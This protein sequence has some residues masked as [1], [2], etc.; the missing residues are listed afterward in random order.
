MAEERHDFMAEEI[1]R[2][3]SLL[4]QERVEQRGLA[5]ERDR[6]V[7]QV[8]LCKSQIQTLKV[9][10]DSLLSRLSELKAQLRDRDG[11]GAS[12]QTVEYYKEL[13]RNRDSEVERLDREVMH[14]RQNGGQG[15]GAHVSQEEYERVIRELQELRRETEEHTTSARDMEESLVQR[16]EQLATS[17]TMVSE[18]AQELRQR[19]EML[20]SDYDQLQTDYNEVIEEL[21]EARVGERAAHARA[22]YAE[23]TVL[24]RQDTEGTN[25]N[26]N[27]SAQRFST[28]GLS[29]QEQGR[30]SEYWQQQQQQQQQ[31]AAPSYR[32][33]DGHGSAMA[34]SP[35][36]TVQ[37]QEHL[38]P[39]TTKSMRYRN[40]AF[41]NWGGQAYPVPQME[42]GTYAFPVNVQASRLA[43]ALALEHTPVWLCLTP[44]GVMLLDRFN[45]NLLMECSYNNIRRF[46][47]DTGVLAFECGR[48]AECGQGVFYLAT[49]HMHDIFDILSRS[50]PSAGRV[51]KVT[52]DN[53]KALAAQKDG[54]IRLR[55]CLPL[56][57]SF[58]STLVGCSGS[59]FLEA[60][61]V[62][63]FLSAACLIIAVVVFFIEE[64]G[65]CLNRD[66]YQPN[67]VHAKA[68]P[69]TADSVF[70]T[71]IV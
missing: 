30:D 38:F 51:L 17:Q 28:A 63:V 54:S 45:H 33:D 53:E 11:A 40:D 43:S 48:S 26:A 22:L 1:K 34:T 12:S 31:Q 61:R 18:E 47:K 23:P 27:A 69:E 36:L 60:Q 5:Y 62:V 25:L 56:T 55:V 57:L 16:V 52:H 49:I 8:E 50:F 44:T 24:Q 3:E 68:S 32:W 9:E 35:P 13:L 41:G 6:S 29:R 64:L 71:K 2:L 21:N 59:D 70:D 4:K 66:L 10:R 15:R 20:Q 67:A 37:A 42:T 65:Y 7:H 46:G 39:N 14:W 19:Y 58:Y